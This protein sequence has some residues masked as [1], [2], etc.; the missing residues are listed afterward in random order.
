MTNGLA[1]AAQRAQQLGEQL[2]GAG[3]GGRECRAAF[4]PSHGI[5]GLL[6]A[7]IRSGGAF[8]PH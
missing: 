3:G 2:A 8:W 5:A 4:A 6:S 1:E 7:G